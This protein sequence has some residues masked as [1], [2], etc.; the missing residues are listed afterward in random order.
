M[1]STEP[2]NSGREEQVVAPDTSHRMV[3]FSRPVGSGMMRKWSAM[4]MFGAQ[5]KRK[6]GLWGVIG[7]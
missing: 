7:A 3:D 5:M 2:G 6:S 4:P 1:N